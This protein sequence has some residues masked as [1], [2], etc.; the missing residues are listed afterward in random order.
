MNSFGF[1]GTNVLVLLDDAYH[2]LQ[3]NRLRGHFYTWNAPLETGKAGTCVPHHNGQQVARLN[4]GSMENLPLVDGMKEQTITTLPRLLVWSAGD[5]AG[6]QQLARAY[7][8]YLYSSMREIDNLAFTLS[9]RRDRFQ[10]KSFATI[11]P[12]DD[13]T[14]AQFE[15]VPPMRSTESKHLA[16]VFT[17]QGSQ[18]IGMGRQLLAYPAFK[19]SLMS[20]EQCL[21]LL[22]CSWSLRG[23]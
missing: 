13:A 9:T 20:S 2:Y 1:G 11:N 7:R 23:K 8:G 15:S 22:N 16:F 12:S 14:L 19:N 21:R 5:K 10:Y 18:Y 3:K 17:G 4:T 6:I